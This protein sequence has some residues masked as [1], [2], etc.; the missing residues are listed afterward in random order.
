MSASER[1]STS[2]NA[3]VLHI[4]VH[5]TGSTALQTALARARPELRS[6]GVLYPGS[7]IAH[8]SAA[9]AATGFS[10]GFGDEATTV[11]PRNWSRLVRQVGRHKGR[12]MISS[13]FFGRMKLK[14]VRRVVDAL[15]PDRVHV[16]FAVRPLADLLPSSW[17]QYLKTGFTVGYEDW[18]HDVL[19]N[20]K[21]TTT[22]GF[23]RRAD[24]GALVTR[25]RRV[26]PPERITAVMLDPQN[27]DLIYRATE[28]L[29]GLPDGLLDPYRGGAA[30][31]SMTAA[32][33]ELIRT[34]NLTI[35]DRMGWRD[36]SERIRHGAIRAMVE[37]RH[38]DATEPPI[39]TPQ[40]ALAKARKR[41]RR[42]YRRL[43]RSGINLV[44]D[45]D[46]LLRRRTGAPVVIPESV[47][48]SAAALGIAV[49][50]GMPRQP[51]D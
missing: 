9:W 12:V 49:A 18:L 36:Y 38:P 23:W 29:L 45:P 42:D 2:E 16:V 48:L 15:G 30:N 19:D 44:G 22:K 24:F 21:P 46:T 1:V 10:I 31:R 47:P 17:Q 14:A 3:I 40:W 37:D 6:N 50:A 51:R 41:Q 34:V 5:K 20:R 7:D 25:W 11:R 35:R 13:E 27:H 32:E 4:G 39:G 43:T 8:H 26:L 33:A 28:G